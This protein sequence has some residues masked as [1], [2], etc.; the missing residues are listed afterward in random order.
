MHGT[1]R[2][3]VPQN[4]ITIGA[5]ACRDESELTFGKLFILP[6][7]KQRAWRLPDGEVPDRAPKPASQL[8]P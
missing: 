6:F 3:D 1:L 5:A 8:A 4:A 2:V 7:Q